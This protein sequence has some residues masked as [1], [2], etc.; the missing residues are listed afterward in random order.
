MQTA[1]SAK[2]LSFHYAWVVISVGLTVAA[3]GMLMTGFANSFA[4][5]AVWRALTGIGSG[6]SNVPVMGLLAA[7][8]VQRRRGLAAGVGVTGSSL[9]LI[10]LGP[11]V[12]R[13]LAAYGANGWGA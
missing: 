2:D 3:A 13:V 6:A 11:L 8:V 10:V 9:A 5:A 7:W 12:P 4:T 1:N